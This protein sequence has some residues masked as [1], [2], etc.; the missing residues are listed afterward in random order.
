VLR[1]GDTEAHTVTFTEVDAKVAGLIG[2]A[3]PWSQYPG[4]MYQMRARAFALRDKFADV[5]KGMSVREEVQDYSAPLTSA[6]VQDAL[7][8]PQRKSEVSKMPPAPFDA[9]AG[10]PEGQEAPR[11]EHL[12]DPTTAG[13]WSGKLDKIEKQEGII[14]SGARKGQPFKLFYLH[15]KDGNKFATFSETLGAAAEGYVTSGAVVV[16]DYK[17]GKS[18]ATAKTIA[19][20]NPEGEPGSE[21]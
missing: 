13:Q 2:K 7:Q 19:V 11:A 20:A 1:K 16:I 17:P 8:Q 3:G 15:A 18:C 10:K 21:G 9:A 12:V 6:I 14:E 4:R 5:L